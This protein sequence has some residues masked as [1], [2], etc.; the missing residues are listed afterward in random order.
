MTLCH[1]VV[2]CNDTDHIPFCFR[3]LIYFKLFL[4]LMVS[5]WSLQNKGQ[6][7]SVGSYCLW[8]SAGSWCVKIN[9]VR[10]CFGQCC[11]WWKGSWGQTLSSHWTLDT[12]GWMCGIVR[13]KNTLPQEGICFFFNSAPNTLWYLHY[14]K[15]MWI[16]CFIR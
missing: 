13:I 11:R 16:E 6:G 3:F 2:L 15:D 10:Q 8:G 7:A 12:V 14:V 9:Q 4:M 5:Q 1:Y